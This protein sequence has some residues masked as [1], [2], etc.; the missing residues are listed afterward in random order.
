MGGCSGN[1]AERTWISYNA[2]ISACEKGGQ[3]PEALSLLREMRGAGRH[4][5][6]C[7]HQRV[8]E[9]RAV[10]GVKV[11]L[12]VISYCAGI[13]ACEKGGQWPE[14]LSLLREMAEVKLELDV[15]S[16]C[17]GISACGKG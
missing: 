16:Y 12:D 3:W 15:I 9:G 14:T 7:Q 6:Q 5:L 4:Q 2:G 13:S 8:R 1:W 10:A 11:E 17:A